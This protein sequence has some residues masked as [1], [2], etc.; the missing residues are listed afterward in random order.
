MTTFKYNL[1]Q[2][3]WIKKLAS[4]GWPLLMLRAIALGGFVFAILV[5]IF[6]TPVG[7]RNFAIVAV[8][9]AWWAALMLLIVPFL[10]RGWCA[11]CPIPMPGEWLQNG[12]VLGPKSGGSQR[13][14]QL[15][16]FPRKF[17]NIW[18]QNVAFTLLALFSAVILTRPSV[19]AWV[20]LGMILL[21]VGMSMVFE[22]R[23]FCRYVCPV[24][25]FIGLYSQLAPVEVRVID[26]QVCKAHTEKSCYQG[27]EN[28]FGCPWNIFPGGM[29]PQLGVN[30]NCGLCM[31]CL[32]TCDYDNIALNLRAFGAD[33]K[34]QNKPKLDEAYK[35]FIMLGSALVYSTVMLG[36]WGALKQAAYQVG[37]LPWFGYA[38]ALLA[39][40]WGLLPGLFYLTGRAAQIIAPTS[41]P[42][43]QT[44]T[45]YA[46]ALL[47]L[48][49]TAWV[50][51]SFSFVFANLSYLWPVLSDPFG[52]GWNLMGTAAL[53]WTPY[54]G[55]LNPILQV[56]VLIGGL[57]WSGS[58][59]QK[60]ARERKAPRQA[61][62]VMM[63]SFFVTILLLWLL[64]A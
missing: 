12:A 35:A 45:T 30:T 26:T 43:R 29:T 2:H 18:L 14:S 13:F 53:A 63:F 17:R 56:L 58:I 57:A 55:Y 25:G 19:T 8:W 59:A 47:P 7:N 6:G 46:A 23:S 33:V 24:G 49:L 28:G 10:G 4:S 44:F 22:R 34:P 37:S 5:G 16:K 62:P 50:A 60:I 15:R 9:I 31:E 21:A 38:L 64:I 42:P 27:S 51:F 11:V 54:F 20:L 3:T 61:G 41:H 32:R 36:P 39:L 1:L 48:G 40:T 52:W